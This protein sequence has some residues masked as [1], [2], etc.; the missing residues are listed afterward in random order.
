MKSTRIHVLIVVAGLV[1][2]SKE[3]RTANKLE[4][5]WE[6]THTEVNVFGITTKVPIDEEDRITLK[7]DECKVKEGDCTGTYEWQGESSSLSYT[8]E[9]EGGTIE[10]AGCMGEFSADIV[11]LEKELLKL[12]TNAIPDSL[13]A[14]LGSEVTLILAKKD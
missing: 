13:T 9:G 10:C 2:C 5:R 6:S 4:G 14:V 3:Q 1:S 7:L 12:R 8:V 11:E